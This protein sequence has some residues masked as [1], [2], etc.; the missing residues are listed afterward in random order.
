MAQGG[1]GKKLLSLLEKK[2]V[3]STARTAI[4]K[5]AEESNSMMARMEAMDNHELREYMLQKK[6]TLESQMK[7]TIKKLLRKDKP[8]KK[9]RTML[10]PILGATL[11]FHKDDDMDPAASGAVGAAA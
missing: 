8:K 11:K 2:D 5:E 10:C 1:K 4:R 6:G 9:K 7:T 3:A